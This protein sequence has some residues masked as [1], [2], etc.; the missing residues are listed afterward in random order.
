MEIEDL[1]QFGY[2]T[3]TAT[4]ANR[5]PITKT[6]TEFPSKHR[7][8]LV[9]DEGFNQ[10]RNLSGVNLGQRSGISGREYNLD[11]A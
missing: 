1:S 8:V 6:K 5:V 4:E 2:N 11:M 7:L 10:P 3:N 9:G